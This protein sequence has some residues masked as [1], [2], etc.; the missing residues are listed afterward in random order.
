LTGAL[1]GSIVL[2]IIVPHREETMD[3]DATLSR[4]AWV[5]SD[6]LYQAYHD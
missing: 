6:P 4:C 1:T 2:K 3:S 5:G